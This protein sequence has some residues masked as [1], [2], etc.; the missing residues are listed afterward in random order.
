MI[1]EG[2]ALKLSSTTLVQSAAACRPTAVCQ[3]VCTPSAHIDMPSLSNDGVTPALVAVWRS[4]WQPVL[5]LPLRLSCAQ[6]PAVPTPA[7]H[8]PEPARA[9]T[10][11]VRRWH[12]QWPD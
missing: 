1:A 5:A 7:D 4:R 8:N 3:P 10:L 11:W 12:H 9:E 2:G 6:L